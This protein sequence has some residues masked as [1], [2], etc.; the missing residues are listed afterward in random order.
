MAI[1]K[2]RNLKDRVNVCI[3]PIRL[4]VSPQEASY[5]FYT[6]HP[7]RPIIREPGEERERVHAACVRSSRSLVE[8][9]PVIGRF[10]LCGGR[11]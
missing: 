4:P 1:S 8:R 3:E 10:A 2:K 6:E 7:S 9:M 5:L 11:R